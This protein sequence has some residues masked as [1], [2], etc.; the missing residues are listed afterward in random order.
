MRIAWLWKKGLFL[1]LIAMVAGA[2]DRSAYAQQQDLLPLK[3]H[4]STR[5][6]NKLINWVALEEGLYKKNG[7]D[8]QLT[9][10]PAF[11]AESKKLSGREVPPQHVSADGGGTYP[12]DTDPITI[13]GGVAYIYP[14]VTDAR[15]VKRVIIASTENV[16]RWPIISRKDITKPEQ[17]KGK[18]LGIYVPGMTPHFQALLFV[19]KMGWDPVQDISLMASAHDAID[20]RNGSVDAL[21]ADEVAAS[22]SLAEGYHVLVDMAQWKIPMASNSVNVERAWLQN[23]RETARRFVKSMVEAIA[24]MKQDKNVAFRSM[25][26]YFGITDPGMQAYFYKEMPNMPRKPY[27]AVD[28]IK[29]TMEVYDSNEMRKHKPEDFYDD[30][31]VRELDQSGFIDSLYK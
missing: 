4:S 11:A 23:N 3:L 27:P 29:K 22:E 7:L 10:S 2:A 5:S 25:A 21:V 19:K 13:G 9:M 14:Q 15:A 6:L 16:T 8:V 17:L 28:G 24:L 12:H 31:F 20:L 18:R 30:S 26:K 1:V